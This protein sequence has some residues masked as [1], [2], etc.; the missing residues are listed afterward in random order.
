MQSRYLAADEKNGTRSLIEG[1]AWG[2]AKFYGHWLLNAA[3][4]QRLLERAGKERR[5][6]FSFCNRSSRN[7]AVLRE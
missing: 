3:K 7:I 4:A 2:D 6:K 5:S 1:P